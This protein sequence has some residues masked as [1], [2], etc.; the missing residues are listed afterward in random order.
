MD[1]QETDLFPRHLF[2]QLPRHMGAYFLSHL[3]CVRIIGKDKLIE[4]RFRGLPFPRPCY[5]V[6]QMAHQPCVR[7]GIFFKLLPERLLDHRDPFID[8]PGRLQRLGHLLIRQTGMDMKCDEP[9]LIVRDLAS[10]QL[11]YDLPAFQ[12]RRVFFFKKDPDVRGKWIG[13]LAP[14]R[15]PF[16]RKSDM[17]RH[18]QEDIPADILKHFLR[19]VYDPARCL[20]KFRPDPIYHLKDRVLLLPV[21]KSVDLCPG[22]A[23]DL[24]GRPL[25]KPNPIPEQDHLPAG[26]IVGEGN[27]ANRGIPGFEPDTSYPEDAT[28]TLVRSTEAA[29]AGADIYW[30]APFTLD[31]EDKHDMH[32]WVTYF[33][34]ANGLT[35]DD[36]S[37]TIVYSGGN[38]LNGGYDDDQ[39]TLADWY[40][41]N[42]RYRTWTWNNEDG[43]PE[44]TYT[45]ALFEAHNCLPGYRPIIWDFM[46]H[47]RVD[48]NDDGTVTRYYSA[49]AFAEDDAVVIN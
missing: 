28:D 17:V 13:D 31:G 49:S 42:A 23:S 10:R 43:I 20:D 12:G 48:T 2:F 18:R 14:F 37:D 4:V 40:E 39:G 27:Y 15:R 32:D 11:P 46:E 26:M 44:I 7:Q 34:D 9:H 25:S 3:S 41:N 8:D 35:N 33:M 47:Y 5:H 22:Q 21:H 38:E 24:L 6:I 29:A 30:D 1:R 45:F 16:R 19:F 36:L